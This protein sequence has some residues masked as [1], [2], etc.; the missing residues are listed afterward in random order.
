MRRIVSLWFPDFAVERFIRGR[1]K[2]QRPPPPKDLPFALV[3]SGTRG[4]RLAA[5]N[6]AARGFG[7][8]RGQRLA[9]A[10]AQVPDLLSELHEPAAD[11]K[12]L[13]GLCRWLERYSPWVAPEPPDG[14][15]LD[16]AGI[17]HLFGG[18]TRMLA[19]IRDRLAAYGF[20]A[21][22]GAGETI[23][24]AWALARY[25]AER[26]DALP[27]EALRVA[28]EQA[29][30]LRRLGLKTVGAL[31]AVPRAAL[32]RRFRGETIGENVLMHLDEMMGLRSEPLNPLNPATSFIAHRVLME[33]II[34]PEGLE[35]ML[36]DLALVLCRDL[37]GKARGALRLLLKL[38]RSDGSRV[39]L[40]AGFSAPTH[41]P[42][43]M[44]RVLKP[45]L[46]PVDA[47]F[48]VDAMTLE[49]RETAAIAARQ[50]GFMEEPGKLAIE[51][52]DDR[53]RNRHEAGLSALAAV[54]SHIPERAERNLPL[55]HDERRSGDDDAAPRT[56]AATSRPLLIF[57]DPEPANVL[58]S[59]PDGPPVRLTWRRVTR[60]VVKS[61]GPERLA[62]EWWRLAD[63]ER[64]RDYYV[65]EDDH[66]RRYWLYREGLYGEEGAGR[67]KWFVHGLSA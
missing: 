9:D 44:L 14:I 32:A 46:E 1:I 42:R 29:L 57:A 59:V 64:P 27:V 20:T 35:A 7:L 30:T 5:V 4:L 37:E 17:P 3:E 43:H 39:S 11:I 48:G 56:H 55:A 66:G 61:Q 62:P 28:G 65:V 60:R 51:Q 49:A 40:P 38:F 54:E 22:S 36:E 50:H 2:E 58:A 18:E 10:R 15:L 41:D 21:R 31:L 26:L 33:P 24:A 45:K 47:G 53:L 19:E 67:P 6:R 25:E 16:I 23:G 52:L 34:S 13:L 12:S 8:A 63:G